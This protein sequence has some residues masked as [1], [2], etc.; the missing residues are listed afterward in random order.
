MNSHINT[1][2]WQDYVKHATV[3]LP[4]IFSRLIYFVWQSVIKLHKKKIVVVILISP[5]FK[6]VQLRG[7]VPQGPKQ[8][9]ITTCSLYCLYWRLDLNVPI[10]V[11]VT[12]T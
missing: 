11:H 12:L 4:V 5:C 7:N 9:C 8:L 1:E 3:I 6:R 2:L 10:H